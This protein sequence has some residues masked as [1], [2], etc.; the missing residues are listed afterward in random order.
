MN[1]N[2]ESS[3]AYLFFGNL[4]WIIYYI[5]D[6]PISLAELEQAINKMSN[7]KAPEP[8]LITNEFYK[9]LSPLWI[10]YL[11]NMFSILLGFERIPAD[12]T[13]PNVC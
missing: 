12:S 7:N 4:F 3:Y 8:E 2:N 10:R 6:I 13:T 11:L 1:N 5:Q 9:S